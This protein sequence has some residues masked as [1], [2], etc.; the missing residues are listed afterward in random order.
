M[1]RNPR[2]YTDKL[3]DMVEEGVLNKN[4]VIEAFCTYMSEADIQDMM[5]SNGMCEPDEFDPTS[6]MHDPYR[7]L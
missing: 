1:S 7:R 5:E 2:Q 4:V 6:C 3:L